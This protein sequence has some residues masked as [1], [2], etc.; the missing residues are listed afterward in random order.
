MELKRYLRIL[1][2]WW[3]LVLVV[4][5]TVVL[6]TIA[7]T[8][9]RT[10][11]YETS[12]RLI[13]SPSAITGTD[14][15]ELRSSISDLD[16]PI[17]ANTYAEIGQSP[18]I[19]QAAWEQLEMKPQKDF[20][21][22][23]SVL[24]ETSIV[25]IDVSGPNP[26]LVQ[27]LATAVSEQTLEYVAGFYEVYDLTLL[28]PAMRPNTPTSPNEKL[29]LV[30]GLVLGI[31][32]GGT[33]AFLAE[34]L[35]VPLEQSEQTSFVDTQTGAYKS[36]YFLRRLREEISR[37]KRVQRPFVVGMIRLE[38]FEE[39]LYDLPAGARQVIL[40]KT[41]SFLKQTLPEEYLIAQWPNDT[42]A[43]LL[44]DCDFKT[45]WQTLKQIQ[46]K[47]AWTPFEIGDDSLKLNLAINFG[48][49]EYDL[50]EKSAEALLK[51][52]EKALQDAETHKFSTKDNVQ[53]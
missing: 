28:D 22:S 24:Q 32:L 11:E 41:V 38:D 46:A 31:A 13:V 5:V 47:L 50:N 15:R 14:L 8:Y 17:V 34:Y 30:L 43:L 40:K 52:V 6:S 49:V 19:I 4:F 25:I 26:T 35:T 42:L 16:K 7:F 39:I 29:N 45:A 51:Q 3:W 37:A 2:H 23:S 44:P 36:S 20:K 10:P 1:W 12:V 33:C 48:L 9:T 53:E 27:Q 21:V 18:F